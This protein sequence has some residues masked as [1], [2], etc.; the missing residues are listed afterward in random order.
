[1]NT[2]RKKLENNEKIRGTIVCLT[3]PCLCEII[4]NVGFDCVWIDTEHTYMSYKDVLCHLNSAR[5]AGITNV[6][7]LPQND[8]TATKKI[9]EM[10][11]DGIIFPMVRS[12][13]EFNALM[14]MTLYPPHGHRG[15]G[16]MRAIDYN[17]QNALDYVQSKSLELCR[18]MQI[19]SVEMIN[20]L[21]EI[22]QNKFIDGFIFGPNDLSGSVGEFLNVYGDK[23]VTEI[24][25]AIEILR[26]H[27]KWVGM[28]CG[29]SPETVKFW[30]RFGMDMI[31]AG[32]DWN[33]IYS[34]AEETLK[35]L[36]SNF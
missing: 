18:F 27:G 17:A 4:G 8:L 11:P 3:D 10:G 22:A 6:V 14:D 19:E 33:I 25:R 7:R 36:K 29:N 5:S 26:R 28:A 23:T 32:G 35:T 13:D 9:L 1:M 24:K 16:P 15:F 21:E 30:A 31:F 2:L 20:D 12:L 34:G